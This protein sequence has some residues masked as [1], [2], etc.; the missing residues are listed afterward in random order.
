MSSPKYRVRRATLDDLGQLMGIWRAMKFRDDDLAKRVTEFQI[1]EN[2]EGKVVGGVGLQITQRQGLIH[3]E[4]FSDFGLS[5]QIRPLLWDR[6]QAVATNHGLLRLW[7]AEDAP[8][9]SHCGMQKSDADAL[10]KLPEQWRG[11]SSS[12]LTLKLK[13]DVEEVISAE[14]EFALFMESEKQR[15]QKAIQQAKVLKAVATIL[16]F[17]LLALVALGAFFILKK[18]PALL[19]R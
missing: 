6:L 2:E 4:A 1:A 15:S 3:S 9:W 10:Q 14:K 16:A 19:H 11:L 18:N 13:E 7:T 17:G 8:F 12:W 5:D